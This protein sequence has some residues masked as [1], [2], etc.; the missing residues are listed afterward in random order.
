MAED[1]HAPFR[2][3]L[4]NWINRVK[5]SLFISTRDPEFD[6]DDAALLKS[7]F[8]NRFCLWMIW[9]DIHQTKYKPWKTIYEANKDI[10][11]NDPDYLT[12]GMTITIPRLPS[13]EMEAPAPSPEAERL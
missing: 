10:I 13:E 7:F 5:P 12:E 6:A 1:R 8:Q 2:G 9:I 11:G 3:K 4:Q